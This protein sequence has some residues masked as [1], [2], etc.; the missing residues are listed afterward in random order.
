MKGFSDWNLI[1]IKGQSFIYR[2]IAAVEMNRR[3]RFTPFHLL[4]QLREIDSRRMLSLSTL[5]N[6]C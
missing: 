3:R 1:L 2:R 6:F 5:Q 4:K